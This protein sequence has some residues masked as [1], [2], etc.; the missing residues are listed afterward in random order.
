MINS[1][2]SPDFAEQTSVPAGKLGASIQAYQRDLQT[3]LVE[4]DI[5]GEV[6]HILLFA[7]GQ[8]VTVYRG[9]AVDR[10]E[11]AGW[12]ESLNGSSPKASLRM[13]ALTPQDVRIFKILIEQQS[14]TR[15]ISTGGLSLEKQFLEWMEHAVPAL[16]Q[17][18]WPKAE[19]LVSF[20]GQGAASYYTLFINANQILHSAGGLTEI[21]G[22]KENYDS[23]RL[24][25][26]EP[27][28]LA[29]TEYLLHQAFSGL[30]SNLLRKFEK[31]IGRILLNQ[32]IRDV[33]FKATAHDWNLSVNANS[34]NDQT[35]FVSPAAAAEVYS[36]LLE[37]IFHHIE[38]VLGATMLGMLVSEA[39][40][41]LPVSDRQVLK[42]YLPI[43]NLN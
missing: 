22:W 33:N 20:P 30:V 4:V 7:R 19:A 36:H 23:V 21:Y 18:R 42:E 12:I 32:I 35:I 43:T 14:D 29:W 25:S 9:N 40:H 3:G 26:S 38:S 2:F 28:T 8:L 1:L 15:C 10:L 16:V 37:V 11:S 34:V 13:L 31:L 6:G 27:R 5:P 41:R 17:V 39:I 24:F